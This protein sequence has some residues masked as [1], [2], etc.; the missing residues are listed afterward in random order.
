MAVYGGAARL[1]GPVAL[2]APR[3]DAL[4]VALTTAELVDDAKTWFAQARNEESVLYFTIEAAGRLVGQIVLHDIDLPLREAMVGYHV[5]RAEDRGQGYGTAALRGLCAYAAQE[6]HLRR[7]VAITSL[8]NSPSRRR[9]IKAGF[10][11]IGPA[12]EGP[13]LIAYEWP[14][15]ESRAQQP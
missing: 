9:A 1:S 5:F 8:D 14:S 6:M 12:R 11:E 15:P 2:T 4:A 13:H 10:R 7:L 3:P